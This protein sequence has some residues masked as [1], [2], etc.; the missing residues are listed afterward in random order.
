M[1]GGGML[2]LSLVSPEQLERLP[3]LSLWHYLLGWSPTDGT[4]RALSAFFHGRLDQAWDYNVNIAATA[5]IIIGHF[6]FDL[7]AL[8]R[9]WLK[10]P[11]HG[12]LNRPIVA[13]S[14]DRTRQ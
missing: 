13:S 12:T 9:S 7:G 3:S 14:P 6:L 8:A 10:K 1:L 11:C 5:P 2:I 4:L